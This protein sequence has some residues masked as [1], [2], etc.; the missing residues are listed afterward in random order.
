MET[1][2]PL[3]QK[4]RLFILD[5]IRG[6]ALCG[7]L[8]LNIGGF[9]RPY[10]ASRNLLVYNETS[11]VD[12]VSWYVTNFLVEGSYRG[13]FS[14]LFGAGMLLL[15][16]RLAKQHTGL[17]AAD[18]YYRRLIWLLLFGLF[19]A[20]VLLWFGDILYAYALCG[21]FLFPFRNSSVKLLVALAV[22]CFAVTVYKGW[23]RTEERLAIRE[24][25]LAALT[26]EKEKKLLTDKQ[27]EDLKAW[28]AIEE[29]SS[30]PK[31]REGA[32]KKIADMQKSYPEVWQHLAP[33]IRAFESTKIY[34]SFFFD[35][36]LF[37]F[38]GMAF[39][40]TG[41]LTG[42]KPLWLYSLFV[43]VGYALG[44]GWG[45]LEG[46]AYRAANFDY[47]RYLEIRPIKIE[48]YQLHRLLVTGGHIGLIV[49]AWKSGWM[50]WFLKAFANVGQ[51]AFTNYL[52][53]SV[54]CTLFFHGYGLGFY[55]KLTR[56]EL[57]YVVVGVWVFQIIFSAIWL[58]YFLYGPL[59]WVWRS[60]TYWKRQPLLRTTTAIK[61]VP[62]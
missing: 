17:A 8:I 39:Y 27:Q 23:T 36:M 29:K 3:Q 4:E 18:I 44:F 42:D 32:E 16:H 50:D 14:M 51:L 47:Y 20:Y 62:A 15:V 55:G 11:T 31:L 10:Q 13:L 6:I 26:L 49:L 48:I 7:I 5:A 37:I 38:L 33:L 25:A 43:V 21:L 59:E 22:F 61:S 45:I 24:R 56:S 30:L 46:N 12:L 54:L 40:K 60:L 28:K 35:V 19:N 57:W 9:A 34:D 2:Q 1:I 53:Q 52:M 41:I 58:R